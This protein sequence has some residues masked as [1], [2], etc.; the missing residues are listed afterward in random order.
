M[1]W[2]RSLSRS[3]QDLT[4][5]SASCLE[6]GEGRQYVPYVASHDI[7][8]LTMYSAIIV[9]VSLALFE[10]VHVECC[11]N[12]NTQLCSV[13]FVQ[14]LRPPEGSDDG[15]LIQSQCISASSRHASACNAVCISIS[16]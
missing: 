11:L 5:L 2:H 9:V 16:L 10:Y 14:S 15:A 4:F 1:C 3:G 7:F 8:S 12:H 6:G 13:V